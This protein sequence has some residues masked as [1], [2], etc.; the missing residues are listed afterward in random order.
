MKNISLSQTNLMFKLVSI[1]WVSRP[2]SLEADPL[3]IGRKK[4]ELP[5]GQASD[6]ALSV[7]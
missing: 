3:E 2:A 1:A 6:M 4:L 7:T 5:G